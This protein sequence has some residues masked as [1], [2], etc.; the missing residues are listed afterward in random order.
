MALSISNIIRETK[1]IVKRKIPGFRNKLTTT[2][3]RQNPFVC[4]MIQC[5]LIDGELTKE[6]TFL[7]RKVVRAAYSFVDGEVID[8]ILPE[9]IKEEIKKPTKIGDIVRHLKERTS[10]IPY[11]AEYDDKLH[12]VTFA[13]LV[14]MEDAQYNKREKQYIYTLTKQL[15]VA[16]ADLKRIAQTVSTE[17]NVGGQKRIGNIYR[18][19]AKFSLIN[20]DILYNDPI[21]NILIQIAQVEGIISYE[22][23]EIIK[24]IL[25]TIYDISRI[26]INNVFDR[27]VEKVI[28]NPINLEKL[29]KELKES[30]IDETILIKLA[31]L[32]SLKRDMD[33]EKK[34][35]E[36]K[37]IDKICKLLNVKNE[38]IKKHI[39]KVKAIIKKQNTLDYMK[40]R[41]VFNSIN[42]THIGTVIDESENKK[43]WIT[44]E[45]NGLIFEIEKDKVFI[46]G[47]E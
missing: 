42:G 45:P 3:L 40:D 23:R 16:E 29:S 41:E 47:I 12:L 13:Y 36:K 17:F 8:K 19:I 9:A 37:I 31:Y 15:K 44:K 21:F 25:C 34:E 6:E 28:E 32:I 33:Y 20:A 30:N 1:K 27:G 35:D 10:K 4:V 39:E 7:I 11:D 24:T 46:R 5:G 26:T 14:A 18:N 2:E 22:E 38:D 43:L